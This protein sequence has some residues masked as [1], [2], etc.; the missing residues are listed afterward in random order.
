MRR[1]SAATGLAVAVYSPDGTYA[2]GFG[3]TELRAGRP[4]D[5]DTCF[6]IG[7][8]TKP[9]TALTLATMAHRGALDLAAPIARWAEAAPFPAEVRAGEVTLRHLLA[10]ISGISC[11]PIGFR[12]AFSGQHDPA[13]LWRLLAACTVDTEAPPGTFHYT[14]IGYNIA[15]LLTDR[16]F[17]RPW[18]DMLERE[19]FGPARMRHA[20]ARMSRARREGWPVARPHVALPEGVT[21]IGLQKDD[22]TMHSAGGVIM[23]AH[24][25]VRWLELMSEAGAIGGR[26]IVPAAAVLATRAPIAALRAEFAGYTRTAYGLGWYHVPFRDELMLHHLGGFAGAR[27]H[28]SYIPARRIG[29]AAFVNDSSAA[30]ELTDAIADYVYDRTARRADAVQVF[31]ARIEQLVIARDRLYAKITADRAARA[32]RRST[33]TRPMQEYA[34]RY[35]NDAFGEIEVSASARS[36]DIHFGAMRALAEPSPEPETVRV[37]LVPMQGERIGFVDGGS[38]LRYRGAIYTRIRA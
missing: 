23:S 33:L 34:G 16:H 36:L 31:D 17:G 12:V 2:R 14:N 6:Y 10:H 35:C 38:A 9:L 28:V 22:A 32:A 13:T 29:V 3:V 15:T 7:S 27:A 8:S 19:L 21:P 11:D 25:A 18:Q 1:L 20:S 4:V 30:T 24:D 37:E 5:A 26:Q